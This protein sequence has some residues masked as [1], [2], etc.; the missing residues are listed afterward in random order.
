[1]QHDKAGSAIRCGQVYC[2]V[3]CVSTAH[4]QNGPSKLTRYPFLVRAAFSDPQ[5]RALNDH[6]FI[7]GVPWAQ[8]ITGAA[9]R[10]SCSGSRGP[11]G[12]SQ[13]IFLPLGVAWLNPPLRA[14]NEHCFIVR[15]L[16]AQEANKPPHSYPISFLPPSLSRAACLVSHC[17]RPTRAFWGRALREHRRPSGHH[18]PFCI[19]FP[20]RF[21]AGW[22]GLVPHRAHRGST[23]WSCALCERKGPSRPPCPSLD[24]PFDRLL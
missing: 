4:H 15:V 20:P 14:S 7:V 18:I 10:P 3:Q 2:I 21:S 16:R 13:S 8:R 22:S 17:A 9:L 23:F 6:R 19:S 11:H 12:L 24:C 1:V 5:L